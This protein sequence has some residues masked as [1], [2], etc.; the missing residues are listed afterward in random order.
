MV[1]RLVPRVYDVIYNEAKKHA[2]KW[3]RILQNWDD[4]VLL[5]E[6][7]F[8]LKNFVASPPPNKKICSHFVKLGWFGF[9]K[10]SWVWV[11]ISCNMNFYYPCL[12]LRFWIFFFFLVILSHNLLR[13]LFVFKVF[14]EGTVYENSLWLLKIVA[15]RLVYIRF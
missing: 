14:K 8:A 13:Y 15:E 12:I 7:G 5:K 6:V 11:G 4:L 10:R 2:K 3:F 9:M 1:T